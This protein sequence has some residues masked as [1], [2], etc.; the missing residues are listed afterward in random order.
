MTCCEGKDSRPAEGNPDILSPKY[1][2]GICNYWH[3]GHGLRVRCEDD[4]E[5]NGRK[6]QPGDRRYTLTFK[7]EDGTPLIVLMGRDGMNHFA[8]MIANLMNDTERDGE[9]ARF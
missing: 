3:T 7:L 8:G 6:A 5:A 2:C 1:Q 4:P 9:E